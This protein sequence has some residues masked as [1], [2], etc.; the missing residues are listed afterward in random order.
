MK[1]IETRDDLELLL[2][3]FYNKLL[4][5]QSISY[6]FTDVAKINLE[7]HIPHLTDFWELSLFHTGNYKKNVMKV[8]LDLNEKEMFTPQHFE[9]WL[10]HFEVTVDRLY[11]GSNAEK[12]KTRAH[13]IATV[14]KIKLWQG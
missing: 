13:S 14:M 5:D 10:G 4:A 3:E 11:A 12:I 2:R 8:H 9:T 7:E 6:I 1:D